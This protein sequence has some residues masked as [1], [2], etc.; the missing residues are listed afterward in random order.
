MFY[1]YFFFVVNHLRFLF[2]FFFL[3][4]LWDS[5]QLD[6]ILLFFLKAWLKSPT[7]ALEAGQRLFCNK[8]VSWCPSPSCFLPLAFT[9]VSGVTGEGRWDNALSYTISTHF[10]SQES[11]CVVPALSLWGVTK[12]SPR[13]QQMLTQKPE[14]RLINSRNV[15]GMHTKW[16]FKCSPGVR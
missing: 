1:F 2:F 5:P 15:S 11:A 4:L 12:V 7:G 13:W 16:H 6:N 10:S 8:A 9:P 14:V 3:S